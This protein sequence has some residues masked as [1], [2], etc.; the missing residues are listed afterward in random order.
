MKGARV[1]TVMSSVTIIVMV[2]FLLIS[3][4]KNRE[5]LDVSTV[6]TA[7]PEHK[8]F[9]AEEL[10]QEMVLLST[11]IEIAETGMSWVVFGRKDNPVPT[12]QGSALLST[13][14]G[15]KESDTCRVTV[16]ILDGVQPHRSFIALVL[17]TK[18]ESV[19]PSTV[20]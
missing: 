5:V 15:L 4:P 7:V 17:P 9:R 16:T 11:P 8:V 20:P 1:I 6:T 3:E 19:I 10:P 18:K 13:S 2:A 14:L 12:P